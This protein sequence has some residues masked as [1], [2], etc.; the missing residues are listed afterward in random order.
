LEIEFDLR[1]NSESDI[2]KDGKFKYHFKIT[3]AVINS[4]LAK[5]FLTIITSDSIN[6]LSVDDTFIVYCKYV[7][8]K[9]LKEL[10]ENRDQS[11]PYSSLKH[12]EVKISKS[13]K[14]TCLYKDESNKLNPGE[15]KT[16]ETV[17]LRIPQ[18]SIEKDLRIDG[19]ELTDDELSKIGQDIKP[20][21]DSKLHKRKDPPSPEGKDDHLA[22]KSNTGTATGTGIPDFNSGNLKLTEKKVLFN[23][24]KDNKDQQYILK[25]ELIPVNTNSLVII[26]KLSAKA[27]A[28]VDIAI[29]SMIVKQDIEKNK[30]S[31]PKVQVI[32]EY[33]HVKDH[34]FNI[35]SLI[36]SIK[37]G[38]IGKDTVILIERKQHGEYQGMKDVVLIA[39]ILDH[40]EK[41]PNSL[42]KLP[43][44]IEKHFMYQDAVLYK[45]AKDYGINI[46]GIEGKDLE[47]KKDS[48][49]YNE[50]REQYM[51][52]TINE[53]RNK[54][55]NVVINVGAVHAAKIETA[56]NRDN[57]ITIVGFR[58]IPKNLK[59]S[60]D[61][62][63]S[64]LAN[65]RHYQKAQPQIQ[66][67]SLKVPVNEER[68]AP[69]IAN[70][71]QS[72]SV[73]V[74]NEQGQ[75]Q[76][77]NGSLKVSMHDLFKE[78]QTTSQ[79]VQQVRRQGNVQTN[80]KE[81]KNVQKGE[82]VRRLEAEKLRPKELG[83]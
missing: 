78:L 60:L 37:N 83:K 55:Y 5:E 2:A 72:A 50:N 21:R 67:G 19:R 8:Q 63:K 30:D 1:R 45:A 40:N 69:N 73:A 62:I 3:E 33:D 54:G 11:I 32:A 31:L 49:L 51:I 65:T 13:E 38:E 52:S 76:I 10:I 26:D 14:D 9:E 34:E 4:D 53:V 61:E 18:Q 79:P 6:I 47:I 74:A 42:I 81:Q 24:S 44:N 46:M 57:D 23:T 12:I 59:T 70:S 43:P 7:T 29:K 64:D 27:A 77:Q 75:S 48:K 66:N 80:E 41:N 20:K 15:L 71:T 35:K 56:F 58:N 17:I 82:H 25:T 36:D 68:T 39:E 16:V 22:K 28:E